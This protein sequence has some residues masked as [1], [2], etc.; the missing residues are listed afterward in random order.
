MTETPADQLRAAVEKARPTMPELADWLTC[1]AE[2]AKA[3]EL[4]AEREPC[5]WCGTGINEHALVVA[6]RI[7][8]TPTAEHPPTAD[9]DPLHQAIAAAVWEQCATDLAHTMTCDDPATIATVAAAVARQVLGTTTG[10]KCPECGTSGACNGGP[11]PLTTT[12]QPE[13]EA[14]AVDRGT[15]A[16][17]LADADGWEWAPGFDKTRSPSYQGYLRQADAVL[18]ALAAEAQQPTPAEAEAHQPEHTWAAELHDPL[19][20]EWVPGRR[21]VTRARAVNDLDHARKIAPAWKDGTATERRLVRATT[22]YTVEQL[23]AEAQ[24]PTPAETEAPPFFVCDTN[25]MQM[26]EPP[27]RP[28]T[29]EPK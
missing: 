15:V 26:G 11:C 12:G 27:A 20:D 21:Y 8:G 23:A 29:E 9:S 19:A 7:L 6:R 18:A 14:P 16:D 17:A 4:W 25:D 2:L 1:E 13:T 22:T 10:Q 24:Q 28:A 3:A 5:G